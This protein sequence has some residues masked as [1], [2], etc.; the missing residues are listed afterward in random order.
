M[1]KP[2]NEKLY[3]EVKMDADK[4]YKKSSAYKSGWIVKEY[5]KRGGKYIDDNKP[6]NLKRWYNEKWTDVGNEKYP[7]Y[8]P[9]KRINQDTPLTINEIDPIQLKEQIKLKQKIKGSKNLPKFKKI[10]GMLI[11]HLNN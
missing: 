4:I 3:Q 7:V 1:P 10:G 6:K 11:M 2:T 9:T 5:K 8:R